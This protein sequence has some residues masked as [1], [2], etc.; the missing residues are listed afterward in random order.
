MVKSKHSSLICV[1]SMLLFILAATC[2][3]ENH[4]SLSGRELMEVI[5]A[6]NGNYSQPCYTNRLKETPKKLDTIV[7]EEPEE[8][9]V[10]AEPEEITVEEEPVWAVEESEEPVAVTVETEDIAVEE[11]VKPSFEVDA[12]FAMIP[13]DSL[14]CVR[15]NSLEYS[16]SQLDVFM[17]G[18]SPVPMGTS[19]MARMG[20]AKVLGSPTLSGLAMGKSFAVFA[21]A[22]GD[23]TIPAVYGLIPV[24]D[25]QKFVSENPGFR[26]TDDDGISYLPVN[27][28]VDIMVVQA[29]DFALAT[30]TDTGGN[31]VDMAKLISGG[32]MNGLASVLDGS[33]VAEAMRESLWVY[34]NMQLLAK[35]LGPAA[36]M[37]LEQAKAMGGE[38]VMIPDMGDVDLEEQIKQL[39]SVTLSLTPEPRVLAIKLTVSAMP[40]AEVAEF[41]NAEAIGM[42]MMMIG[43][44][45]PSAIPDRIGAISKLIPEAGD[46]D[47]VGEYNLID[48]V[49]GAMQMS[50]TPLPIPP[51]KLEA[52]SKM[53]MAVT[54][55]QGRIA[56]QIALPKE[57]LAEIAAA[58]MSMQQEMMGGMQP[59]FEE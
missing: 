15:I 33:E 51:I 28:F 54:A 11:A 12:L 56:V 48:A 14:F 13:G 2:L 52:K 45:N 39:R 55:G 35:I 40:G 21:V 41:L 17:A 18:V 9:T 29:G 27:E 7:A 16:L 43:A 25:Y 53:A 4:Q 31:P 1:I 50:P 26:E 34:G 24:T 23:N 10:D 58:A 46:A 8:V 3:A 5:R 57:H 44:Q 38:N 47:F 30:T 20:L 42:P 49:N 37:G 32:E 22:D 36:M 59:N 19:M 6:N